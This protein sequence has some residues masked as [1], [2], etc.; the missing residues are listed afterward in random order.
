MSEPTERKC[1]IC[2]GAEHAGKCQTRSEPTAD[3]ADRP[4]S[5]AD[6]ACKFGEPFRDDIARRIRA[7]GRACARAAAEEMKKQAAKVAYKHECCR[8]GNAHGAPCQYII[9]GD[10]N[11]L[12]VPQ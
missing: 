6:R 1:I 11:A 10:I 5:I 9:G 2:G 3:E 7:Y 4:E 12:E 8:D